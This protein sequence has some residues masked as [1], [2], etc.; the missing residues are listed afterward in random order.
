M[1]ALP[2][3]FLLGSLLLASGLAAAQTTTA[4]LNTANGQLS[5]PQVQVGNTIY[6]NV[7]LRLDAV[8]VVSVGSSGPAPITLGNQASYSGRYS[9]TY[10]GSDTGTYTIDVSPTGGTTGSVFSSSLNQ[11]I[12][13]TGQVSATGSTSFSTAANGGANFFGGISTA[14]QLSGSWT[15]GP[16][17]TGSFSGQRQ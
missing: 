12:P 15:Y 1:R 4:T 11:A 13:V 14:G 10:R 6:F 3:S 5:L 9:G 8:N 7:V 17:L 2:K 16:Q